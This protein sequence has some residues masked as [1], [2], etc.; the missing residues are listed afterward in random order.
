MKVFKCLIL[1]SFYLGL[2]SFSL[3]AQEQESGLILD[4]TRIK[5]DYSSD[6]RKFTGIPSI[7]ATDDG[8]LWITWYAGISPGE[9][10]HNYVVLASS[11]DNGET[12]QEKLIA[13]PD[14]EGEI[15]AFDPQI[16]LAPDNTLWLFW[17]QTVGHDGIISKLWAT[18]STV[19]NND[20]LQWES[21]RELC[22]GI[23]MEKPTVLSDGTWMLPVSTWRNTDYSAKVVVSSDQGKTWSVLGS[24]H[25]PEDDRE[26]DEHLVIEKNDKSLWML[27][28]TNYGIGESFSGDRGKTWSELKRSSIKHASSRFFA[29]RLKSG[30]LLLVK[31]GAIDQETGRSHL[32]AFISKDDGLSWSKGLLIDERLG[33]SY[34]DVQQRGD[35]IYVTYDYNRTTDQMILMTS[36]TEEDIL[37]ENYDIKIYELFSRRK[38]VS[39]GGQ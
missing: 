13:D 12:W 15:R 32:M 38:T 7:A 27:V 20:E 17:A 23:M 3:S 31:H 6:K 8:R 10:K 35:S 25:V 9:D 2:G 30:N 26:F 4:T 19:G 22:N 39:K 11:S 34:P 36:F 1:L 24:C 33:V 16:W 5:S 18:K 14:G 28:R 29:S 21:P 37:S